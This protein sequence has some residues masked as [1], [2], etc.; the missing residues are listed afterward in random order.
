MLLF[1]EDQECPD[2]QIVAPEQ[3]HTALCG[4]SVVHHNVVQSST[5]GRYSNVIL[6]IY[7][8]EITCS[9]CMS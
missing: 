1:V 5:A 4:A 3:L 8:A 9:S 2:T 6:S 7:G